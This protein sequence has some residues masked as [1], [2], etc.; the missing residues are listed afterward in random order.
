MSA[1]RMRP[2][3]AKRFCR[4]L[5]DASLVID[6]GES[7]RAHD[8][9]RAQRRQFRHNATRRARSRMQLA[10][11]LQRYLFSH[12]FYSGLRSATGV[13]GIGALTYLLLGFAPAVAAGTGALAIS[14]THIP[15]PPP[16]KPL[17]KF[18]P[19]ARGILATFLPP[20]APG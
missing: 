12:Y 6:E 1:S 17:G 11:T 16:Q 7:A 8:T 14:I 4:L 10:D 18:I 20:P 2:S 9:G 15:H 3:S 5:M 13:I 19:L